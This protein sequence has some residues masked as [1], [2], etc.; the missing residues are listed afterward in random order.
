MAEEENFM[1]F[2]KK[3]LFLLAG[4]VLMFTF[5]LVGC[6]DDAD[7]GEAVVGNEGTEADID[8][9]ID[10]DTDT[11]TDEVVYLTLG[12]GDQVINL[13]S[14][15]D[16]VPN[17]MEMFLGNNPEYAERYRVEVTIIADTDGA[18][19]IALDQALESG[20]DRDVPH[21]FTAEAAFA[22][23][24]TQGTMAH[25]ALPYAELGID[26]DRLVNEAAIA[27][28]AIEIGTRDGDIV[29]LGFQATGGA[30][31]YRRGIAQSVFG[32]DDPAAIQNIVGPGWDR[33]L[34]AARQLNEA[35][36]AAVSGAGDL[37][38]V[39]RT[40]GSPWV[41][42][43]ELVID[44]V[45][46][47]FM[48]LH[49]ALYNEGLM[50]D[51]NSW[52][53]AWNADMGGLGERE[54]FAFFGPAWLI[55]FVMANH[56]GDT[57]GDWAVAVPPTGF[58]WGGTWLMAHESLPEETRGFVGSFI[59]WV[60]LDSSTDGLQYLWANGLFNPDS[61]VR[62]VVASDAVMDISN[63]EISFLGGQNMFEVF[64]PAGHYADGNAL[65]EYDLLINDWFIDQS[66]LYA[67]GEKTREEAIRDFM[68]QVAD[69]T[70][71]TVNFD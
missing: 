52:T 26:V 6:G 13:W 16:E 33:F 46:A 49:H 41:V 58:F 14:F 9:N 63:G 37:W 57:Y 29:G 43:G 61:D 22:L 17:M 36:Y 66:Q 62:D 8:T 68:R 10:A 2:K 4:L 51:A 23:R 11:D 45:R 28:Y 31:I 12:E 34:D 55:N 67:S 38:Q 18:Y 60:T 1:C 27:S 44:P 3:G 15:T 39:I 53:P 35:G 65:T 69:N 5:V 59:E 54:V 50:N 30:M 7:G 48:T 71:I 21:I 19:M 20:R 25:H 32:T 56:A 64:A 70:A 40:S 47:D 42:D 24:Y